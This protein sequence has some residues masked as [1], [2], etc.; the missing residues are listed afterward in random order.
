[1]SCWP[2]CS[3]GWCEC[4]GDQCQPSPTT[5]NAIRI[6]TTD[7]RY[8]Q[9]LNGGD[10]VILA[11]TATSAPGQWETFLFEA[12]TVWPLESGSPIS[13]RH[14]SN[15]WGP[16]ADLIRVEHTVYRLPK[17]GK[18]DPQLV[19]YQIGG[20]GESV[21][22]HPGFSAGYPAYPGDDPHERIFKLTK[23][24]AGI[25]APDGSPIVD[26]DQVTFSFPSLNPN[27]PGRAWRL[28]DDVSVPHIDGDAVPGGALAP[29][30]FTL[31]FNEVREGLGWRPPQG[32]CRACAAVTAQVSRRIDGRGIAGARVM[33]LAPAEPFAGTTQPPDGSVA[34]SAFIDGAQRTCVPAGK[35]RLQATADRYQVSTVVAQVPDHGQIIVAIPMDCTLVSGR[36]IDQVNSPLPGVWVFLRAQD[37]T[38]IRDEAETLTRLR[39]ILTGSSLSLA[40]RT[41]MSR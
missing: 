24:E 35:I 12:P 20:D 6:K 2:P 26:G 34:L 5:F 16:S 4:V 22:V 11:P 9:A 3:S 13:L 33:A 17:K 15:N 14:M 40:S 30:V 18:K 19:R 28:L 41:D 31:E 32:V 1:M 29:T 36:V 27:E 25:E 21:R 10:G 7:G 8:L 38:L 37:G 39:P 23:I